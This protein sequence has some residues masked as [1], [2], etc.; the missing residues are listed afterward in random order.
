[1]VDKGGR[2]RTS[3]EE[4][5][6]AALRTQFLARKREGREK[7]KSERQKIFLLI[8]GSRDLRL[9]CRQGNGMTKLI[10]IAEQESERGEVSPS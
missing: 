5:G 10:R 9:G 3:R 4:E 7:D 1:M 8:K 2:R 6:G